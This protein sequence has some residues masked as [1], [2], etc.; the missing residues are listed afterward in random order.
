MRANFEDFEEGRVLVVQCKKS[1][2][3]VYV[4]E[5]NEDYFWIRTGPSTTRLSASQTQDYIE[6]RFG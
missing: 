4:K 6:Q 1:P 3:P 5:G 2:V